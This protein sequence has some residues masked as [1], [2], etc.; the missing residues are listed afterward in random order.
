MKAKMEKELW[1]VYFESANYCGYGEYCLVWAADEDDAQDAAGEWAEDSYREQDEQQF[2]EE[3]GDDEDD[4][5]CTDGVMWATIMKCYPLASDE[6]EDI[7][8]YLQD[9][10]QKQFYQIVNT[11]D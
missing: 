9:E 11:K 7:R 4:E 8:G 5:S 10:T 6:G 3:N 2:K 1:V